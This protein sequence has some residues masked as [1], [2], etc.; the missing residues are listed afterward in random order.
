MWKKGTCNWIRNPESGEIVLDFL[1]EPEEITEVLK[2]R[3]S[4]LAVLRERQ[5]GR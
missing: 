4:S 1:R 2:S 3:E 5:D